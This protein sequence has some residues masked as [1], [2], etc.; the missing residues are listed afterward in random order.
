MKAKRISITIPEDLFREMESTTSSVGYKKRSQAVAD[1]I[2]KF[3][4]DFKLL[5]KIKAGRC[6][7]TITFT[8]KHHVRGLS[9]ALTEIQHEYSEIINASLHIHLDEET[10]L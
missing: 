3:V 9:E 4:L 7:G 5:H 10:C 8:Y 1:A 6:A 2:R